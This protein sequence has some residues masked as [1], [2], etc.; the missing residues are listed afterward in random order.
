MCAGGYPFTFAPHSVAKLVSQAWQGL[1]SVYPEKT[2]TVTGDAV[3]RCDGKW[4]GEEMCIRD[5]PGDA[6]HL[7]FLFQA[8]RRMPV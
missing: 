3:I 2:L 1:A 6:V 7:Q 5:R 8:W 4:L